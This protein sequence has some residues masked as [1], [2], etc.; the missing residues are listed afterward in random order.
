MPTRPS[1]RARACEP[2]RFP[3]LVGVER[4]GVGAST[5]MCTTWR[6]DVLAWAPRGNEQQF[7][8][9]ETRIKATRFRALVP[10]FPSPPIVITSEMMLDFRILPRISRINRASS[11]IDFCWTFARC[12]FRIS[13]GH[14][15]LS[16]DTKRVTNPSADPRA[17][18]NIECVLFVLMR[19]DFEE[20]PAGWKRGGAVFSFLFFARTRESCCT[21][22]HGEREREWSIYNR[23]HDSIRSSF[24]TRATR[25]N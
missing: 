21:I 8:L 19:G 25:F 14:F 3:S 12:S 15:F 18:L 7:V 9:R 16:R 20:S 5:I 17:K 23:R 11:S 1:L 13:P 6:R 22:L 2:P 10:T 24:R 4:K